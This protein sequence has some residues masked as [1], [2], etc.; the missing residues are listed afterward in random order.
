[1]YA[2]NSHL[3]PRHVAHLLQ[4]TATDLGAPGKDVVFGAGRIQAFEAVKRSFVSVK[5]IPTVVKL[6]GTVAIECRTVP[7]LPT[8]VVIGA[9][10][11]ETP[12]AGIGTLDIVGPYAL[13]VDGLTS[14]L[15]DFTA[16]ALTIPN[17]PALVG[18]A[19]YLQLAV[20]SGPGPGATWVLSAVDGFVITP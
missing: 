19:F 5:P 7:T 17:E 10:P 16:A 6:M 8:Y 3:E 18:L 12:L 13:L 9:I 4:S 20:T 15:A 2:A 11:G 1:M 14:P